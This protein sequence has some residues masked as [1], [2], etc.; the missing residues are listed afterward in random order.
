MDFLPIVLQHFDFS[1]QPNNSEEIGVNSA[2][3][4]LYPGAH[5]ATS[6]P[7]EHFHHGIVVDMNTQD[8]SIIHFWGPH[9]TDGSIQKTNLPLFLAG[10]PDKLG[11]TTRQL[12]LINYEHDSFEKRQETINR[13]KEMLTK[14]SEV[15]YDLLQSNCEHFAR[16][17]RTGQWESEQIN[18]L[19]DLLTTE[20]TNIFE[21]INDA[22]EENTKTMEAL[23][24][25]VPD[26]SLDAT[27]KELL[28]KFYEKYE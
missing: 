13:A 25:M 1:L 24:K 9:K 5:I 16:Y 2:K 18:K 28:E 21:L 8:L 19:I 14:T 11:K 3:D 26:T 10:S 6:N 15:S 7:Y 17:C 4:H 20:L 23:I 22:N 27:Q 12:Y